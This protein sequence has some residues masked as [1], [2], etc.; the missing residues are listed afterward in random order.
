MNLLT[1]RGNGKITGVLLIIASIIVWKYCNYPRIEKDSLKY[2]EQK[3]NLALADTI[4]SYEGRTYYEHSEE[5]LVFKGIIKPEK[6][7]ELEKRFADKY[8]EDNLSRGQEFP[9]FPTREYA[10][11]LQEEEILNWYEVFFEGNKAMTTLF[12]I[13]LAKDEDGIYYLYMMH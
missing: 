2:A 12:H 8:G 1:R 4:L 11:E 3:L 7:S 9:L 5:V 13:I 10:T 6:S